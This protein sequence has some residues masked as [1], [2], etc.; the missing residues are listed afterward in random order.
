MEVLAW[1]GV[2]LHKPRPQKSCLLP[3]GGRIDLALICHAPTSIALVTTE[4]DNIGQLYPPGYV[5]LGANVLENFDVQ[6]KQINT[7]PGPPPYYRNLQNHIPNGFFDV[8]FSNEDGDNVINGLPFDIE[9]IS[10]TIPLN[11]VQEW[12]LTSDETPGLLHLHPYQ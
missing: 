6:T 12:H 1:D 9:R 7:L 4:Y 3:P 2:F 11:S 8:H 10:H 5:V